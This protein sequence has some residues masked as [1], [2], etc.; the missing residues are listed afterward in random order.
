MIYSVMS[1]SG[2]DAVKQR[3]RIKKTN[4]ATGSD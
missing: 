2:K 3:N 4:I 1:L